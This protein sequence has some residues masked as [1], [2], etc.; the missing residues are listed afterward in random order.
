MR[1]NGFSLIELMVVIAIVAILAGV[2]AP[3]YKTYIEKAKVSK[4][5]NVV[6]GI[7]EKFV[8]KYQQN[9]TFPNFSA[10]DGGVNEMGIVQTNNSAPSSVSDYLFPPSVMF[11]QGGDDPAIGTD[12]G[13][14]TIISYISNYDGAYPTDAAAKIMLYEITYVDVKG[15]IESACVYVEYDSSWAELPN[16]NLLPGC[17]YN[18]NS[19]V[20][21]LIYT[22]CI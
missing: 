22:G 7:G 1:F 20:N 17:G 13:S 21:N 10:I 11:M 12:C 3:V 9:S 8:L 4:A 15:V 18:D 5:A 14:G 19:V 6:N 2:A 16:R